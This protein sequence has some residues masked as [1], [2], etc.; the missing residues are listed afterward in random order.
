MTEGVALTRWRWV[1]LVTLGLGAWQLLPDR[2]MGP[3]HAWN[4]HTILEFVITLFAISVSGQWAVHVWGARYGLLLTGLM[5]GFASGSATIHTMGTVA[6]MQP[7]FADRAVLGGVLSNIATLV[8]MGV[9]LQVLAPQVLTLFLLPVGFGMVGIGVYA[10]GLLVLSGP[11]AQMPSGQRAPLTLDWQSV[12]TLTALVCGVSYVSAAL[13]ATYGQSGLWLGS[14]LSG[15]V[16]A[17]AMV[18]TLAS[19]LLQGK[20]QA[21]D[22]LVPLLMALTAN[23][24]TKCLLAFQSGGWRYASVVSGGVWLTTAAVWL[25]YFAQEAGLGF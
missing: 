18:P 2:Y 19:L 21:H 1:A 16:D 22:A 23:S 8:Q 17:H 20:L 3:Y 9:V 13:N 10:L 6:K 15:L 7:Q 14:A 12:L 25:G 5:G 24:F 4:P 11:A